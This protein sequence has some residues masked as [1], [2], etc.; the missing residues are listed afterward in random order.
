M[1]QWTSAV[2][3]GVTSLGCVAFSTALAST[4][5]TPPTQ[6]SGDWQVDLRTVCA[7]AGVVLP[8]VMWLT[9]KY[10]AIEARLATTEERFNKL[11]RTIEALLARKDH[12]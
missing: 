1:K 8:A 10:A 6:I 11:E 3:M 5:G 9:K 2:L 7:V 4:T 12:K